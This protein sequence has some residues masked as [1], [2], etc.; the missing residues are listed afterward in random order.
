M[1][2]FIYDV[3]LSS[4][5]MLQLA[6]IYI[7]FGLLV[8]GMLKMFLS[9]AYVAAHLGSG[10][11][12]SVFKAALLGIPIPLCSCGVLPAAT[13]LKKQGANN[14]ATTAF[15]IS[16]PES[17]VDSISI[18]WA[19]LDP[20]MTIA[21]PVSAFLSAFAAGCAENYFNPPDATKRATPDLSCP[22]DNCCDGTDC[23]PDEHKHHHGLLEK[24]RIGTTYAATDLWAEL[25]GWFFVGIL[26]SGIIN[27]LVPDAVIARYLGGGLGSMLLMLTFGIPLYICATASTPIAAAFILK[28]VSPGTALVFLLVGPATNV[29]S[30]S[31]LF[32]LLGK[33]ATALYLL[34]IAIISVLCGLAV[35]AIYFSLGISAV[36]SIGQAS[37]ILPGWLMT[38]ATL[39]LL[40]LSIRP[41][42]TIILGWFGKGEGCGCG[43]VD[44]A[45][46]DSKT[47]DHEEDCGCSGQATTV[48]PVQI[49]P[50]PSPNKKEE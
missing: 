8:G 21:R 5:D 49:Q 43:T 20:I 36:A 15:L 29:T 48:S 31:V 18:T 9:P 10:R 28:G 1:I 7:L 32:G 46:G 45:S 17:G 33:R 39:L 11:F 34:S 23:P 25:A 42:Y 40:V 50:F 4:W 38:S 19:L 14:G 26:L 12:S 30:L 16:T 24:L 41:I 3:L 2:Q 37:E 44:C 27:V 35:D 13:S 47:H 22:I 6:S